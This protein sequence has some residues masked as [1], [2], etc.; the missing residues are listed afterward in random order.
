MTLCF[1][2]A[3]MGFRAHCVPRQSTHS[4]APKLHFVK[5]RKWGGAAAAL[6]RGTIASVLPESGGLWPAGSDGQRVV[7][8]CFSD[9]ESPISQSW[10]CGQTPLGQSSPSVSWKVTCSDLLSSAIQPVGLASKGQK[11]QGPFLGKGEWHLFASCFCFFAERYVKS[12]YFLLFSSFVQYK[13]IVY[14]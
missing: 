13:S 1:I 10:C 5:P 11:E 12:Y 14:C 3:R 9:A 7:V 4:K 2:T 8:K 6:L